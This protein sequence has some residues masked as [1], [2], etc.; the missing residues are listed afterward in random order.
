[1]NGSEMN[2]TKSLSARV[3]R[4]AGSPVGRPGLPSFS[5][6]VKNAFSGG[7]K[8]K[9]AWYHEYQGGQGAKLGKR[10]ELV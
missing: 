1:M 4:R 5:F 8:F 3:E 7:V 10:P 2:A 6:W 9:I